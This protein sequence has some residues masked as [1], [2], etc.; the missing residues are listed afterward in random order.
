[1]ADSHSLD[2]TV[3]EKVWFIHPH[4]C[5]VKQSKQEEE[6][7]PVNMR[8]VLKIYSVKKCYKSNQGFFF[9]KTK[10]CV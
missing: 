9:I 3:T 6:Q 7:Q 4:S 5:E 1:M 10:K 8:S 2:G